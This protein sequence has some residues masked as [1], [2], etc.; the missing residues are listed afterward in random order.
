MNRLIAMSQRKYPDARIRADCTVCD[1]INDGVSTAIAVEIGET[2]TNCPPIG[3]LVLVVNTEELRQ[4]LTTANVSGYVTREVRL[5]SYA[6]PEIG[7]EWTRIPATRVDG[8]D[9]LII[10]RTANF[11]RTLA[12]WIK[13]ALPG[14]ADVPIN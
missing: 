12:R 3:K 11:Y 6:E 10:M 9:R 13:V 8:Q 14:S 5:C 4:Q 2:E 1:I 7:E